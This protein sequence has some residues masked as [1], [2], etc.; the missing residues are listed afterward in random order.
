MN[1][2]RVSK[3]AILVIASTL[4]VCSVADRPRID[5]EVGG[6]VG[7][8]GDRQ[9]C[10]RPGQR[11]DPDQVLFLA[12]PVAARSVGRAGQRPLNPIRTLAGPVVMKTCGQSVNYHRY[13]VAVEQFEAP[14]SRQ[15]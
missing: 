7:P 3:L 14:A 12:G 2:T 15:L 9:P 6:I 1:A 8:F 11:V 5:P 10:V 13:K 4:L